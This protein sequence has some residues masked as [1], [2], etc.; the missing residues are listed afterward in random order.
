[1]FIGI[2]IILLLIGCLVIYGCSSTSIKEGLSSAPNPIAAPY[3]K[4]G[5][6][7]VVFNGREY[8]T[9]WDNKPDILPLVSPTTYMAEA[10]TA[11]ITIFD[12]IYNNGGKGWR[13]KQNEY[14]G[15]APAQLL[16]SSQ[17]AADAQALQVKIGGGLGSSKARIAAATADL[18]FIEADTSAEVAAGGAGDYSYIAEFAAWDDPA[19]RGDQ[20]DEGGKTA[21]AKAA[22]AWAARGAPT[23]A[24][25]DGWQVADDNP[26]SVVV[27]KSFPWQSW[28][29]YTNS[30]M[31]YW[32][33][34]WKAGTD[35]NR[36]PSGEG[37]GGLE[38]YAPTLALAVAR[39]ADPNA[40][41]LSASAVQAAALSTLTSGVSIGSGG[42]EY[43]SGFTFL[44]FP[45]LW[46]LD[47]PSA[48][49]RRAF[50]STLGTDLVTAENATYSSTGGF[51]GAAGA[52]LGGFARDDN[53]R[54]FDPDASVYSI[55]S[56]NARLTAAAANLDWYFDAVVPAT[57][58]Y[59]WT[60]G[61]NPV[62][63]QTTV[64][65]GEPDYCSGAQPGDLLL[66]LPTIAATPG[67]STRTDE[68]ATVPGSRRT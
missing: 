61:S 44:G 22:T 21:A 43:E 68:G 41:P 1:M 56:Y 13:V 11:G 62:C 66:P 12:N 17:T 47:D 64:A 42:D 49:S 37:I 63:P 36:G 54:G 39:A 55:D 51:A 58:T 20:K 24:V 28:M 29:V 4:P 19:A 9:I 32:S 23:G 10:K 26:D 38:L 53:A 52:L 57:A 65:G 45:D 40:V 30:G 2:I 34:W 31:S 5:T 18:N 14:S 6:N 16:A 8:R 3:V 60:G 25:P 35:D 50:Y 48:N 67:D 46:P 27:I 59:S 7:I 33:K 15:S